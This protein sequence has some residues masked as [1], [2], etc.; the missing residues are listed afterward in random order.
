M[1]VLFLSGTAGNDDYYEC[2]FFLL[3]AMFISERVVVVV[4]KDSPGP[5][6]AGALVF[7]RPVS[8]LP[9]MTADALGNILICPVE[10][11]ILFSPDLLLMERK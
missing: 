10:S 11:I 5:S 8:P 3:L 9:L 4:G 6:L 2:D 7:R 1:Q